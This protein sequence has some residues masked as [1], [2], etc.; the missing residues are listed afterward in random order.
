MI[1]VTKVVFVIF[2]D[3]EAFVTIL[4]LGYKAEKCLC[5]KER[6]VNGGGGSQLP[7]LPF[8]C[9][10]ELGTGREFRDCLP[11]P[12]AEWVLFDAVMGKP[13]AKSPLSPTFHVELEVVGTGHVC[14][15]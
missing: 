14:L 10:C 5:R 9:L 7:A 2:H 1:P 12:Q 3:Q 15:T 13:K 8:V 4:A 11:P 6:E